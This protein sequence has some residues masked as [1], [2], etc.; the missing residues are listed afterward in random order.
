MSDI[1]DIKNIVPDIKLMLLAYNQF[2]NKEKYEQLENLVESWKKDIERKIKKYTNNK[3]FDL[4]DISFEQCFKYVNKNEILTKN[5]LNE[6]NKLYDNI[7]LMKNFYGDDK[8]IIDELEEQII[9]QKILNR[10][11]SGVKLENIKKENEIQKKE[12]I[13]NKTLEINKENYNTFLANNNIYDNAINNELI[14]KLRKQFLSLKKENEKNLNEIT[15]LK[16][17]IKNSKYNEILI[18]NQTILQEFKKLK[19]LYNFQL[20]EYENLNLKIKEIKEL[21]DNFSKQNFIIIKLKEEIEN[22]NIENENLKIEYE[23]FL[24]L[25][26]FYLFFYIL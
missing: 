14:Y 23:K 6:I 16:K 17:N 7:Q 1:L 20:N 9:I 2:I 4:I 21:K 22:L 25:K 15:L 19:S 3:Y 13:I 24:I 26:F 5:Y 8:N 10:I 12:S 18:E 11:S